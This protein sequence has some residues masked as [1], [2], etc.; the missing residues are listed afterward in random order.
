MN[1]KS[2]IIN[3]ILI[4]V[5]LF[6]VLFSWTI[7][8]KMGGKDGYEKAFKEIIY[9]KGIYKIPIEKE[10]K[11]KKIRYKKG[12]KGNAIVSNN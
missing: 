4:V 6:G 8:Y 1:K 11:H 10:K 2:I 3:S 7:G 9:I 5:L 12:H